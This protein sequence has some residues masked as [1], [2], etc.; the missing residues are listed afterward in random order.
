MAWGAFSLL[1]Q[2]NI[3][4][5]DPTYSKVHNKLKPYASFFDGCIGASDGTHIPAHVCHESRLDNINRKGWPSYNILGI[6]DMDM[7]F[8]FVGA[9]LAGSCHDMAVLRNCMRVANYPHP[10][11]CMVTCYIDIAYIDFITI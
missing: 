6:V 10:P 11:I 9:G 5:K 7:R 3:C 4:P 1:S 2:T 8:T